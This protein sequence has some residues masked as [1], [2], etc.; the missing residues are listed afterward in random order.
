MVVKTYGAN[1]DLALDG[2]GVDGTN[3][4]DEFGGND[5]DDVKLSDYYS[6]GGLVPASTTG[7][8]TDN[9]TVSIPSSGEISFSNFFA[10]ASVLSMPAGTYTGRQGVPGQ[11]TNFVVY[12]EEEDASIDPTVA[13]S[14]KVSLGIRVYGSTDSTEIQ[15]KRVD[16]VDSSLWYNTS[17][18]SAT[19]STSW[20]TIWQMDFMPDTVRLR[21]DTTET[22]SNSTGT[23]SNSHGWD[24]LSGVTRQFAT[25]GSPKYT[26]LYT[27]FSTSETVGTELE[28]Q[29]TSTSASS[30]YNTLRYWGLTFDF[31]KTGYNDA[32]AHATFIS[33]HYT[34]ATTA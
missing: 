22:T 9:G 14:A 16:I 33:K 18:V 29:S 20:Q 24:S 13:A 8:P 1:V 6:D 19:L 11:T 4:A 5:R 31:K 7:N 2:Y 26:P 23:G 27:A 12:L 17:N 34:S 21:Y 25:T 28:A 10:S 32:E 3:I 15:V 30:V